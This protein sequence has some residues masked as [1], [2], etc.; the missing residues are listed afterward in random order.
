MRLS[1]CIRIAIDGGFKTAAFYGNPI[2]NHPVQYW[3]SLDKIWNMVVFYD[4]FKKLNHDRWVYRKFDEQIGIRD[5]H[6][7]VLHL[8]KEPIED[9]INDVLEAE[10]KRES[11]AKQIASTFHSADQYC[12]HIWNGGLGLS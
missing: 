6:W 1:E 2:Q 12:D 10:R 5:S 4:E 7:S 9:R 8:Y 11:T 3:A